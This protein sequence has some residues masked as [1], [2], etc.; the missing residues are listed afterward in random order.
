MSSWLP[1]TMSGQLSGQ[2]QCNKGV[3]LTWLKSRFYHLPIRGWSRSLTFPS[4]NALFTV[5]ITESKRI[6]LNEIGI[7]KAINTE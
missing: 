6:K 5:P 4:V 3:R 1:V 2:R 7:F